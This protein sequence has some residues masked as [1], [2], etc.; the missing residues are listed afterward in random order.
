MALLSSF[1]FSN[2]RCNAHKK[3]FAHNIFYWVFYEVYNIN[4][5]TWQSEDRLKCHKF[6]NFW[7]NGLLTR[8]KILKVIHNFFNLHQELS[9]C[10]HYPC[11]FCIYVS[12]WGRLQGYEMNTWHYLLSIFIDILC[13]FHGQ[14]INP[15]KRWKMK[16]VMDGCFWLWSVFASQML[17]T[18]MDNYLY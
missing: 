17:D 11:I 12:I 6:E 7:E 4:F 15:F 13:F 1:I 18:V 8:Q 5:L 10:C 16:E 14:F 2:S 3:F 9:I